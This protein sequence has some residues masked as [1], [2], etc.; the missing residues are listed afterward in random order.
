MVKKIVDIPG[1]GITTP[2]G[3]ALWCNNVTPER[4]YTKEG[5]LS[6]FLILDPSDSA[7]QEFLAPLQKICDEA[8]E[9][10]Q[11]NLPAE[12]AKQVTKRPITQE[13]TDKDGNPTG[14]VK[15]KLKLGKI[16]EKKAE[17]KQYTITTYDAKKNE[18][19]EPPTVGNGSTIRCSGFAFPYYMASSKEVGISIKWNALQIIDLK[20]SSGGGADAFDEEDGFEQALAATEEAIPF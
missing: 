12:K 2:K 18:I 19:K 17:G 20:S 15:V 10:A 13:D 11:K 9:Q 5:D 16:D 14:K 4:E 1:I 7:V 3:K 6:T 8:F